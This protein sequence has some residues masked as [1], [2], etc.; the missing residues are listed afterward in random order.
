MLTFALL[1][2]LNRE[3]VR[4]LW[5]ILYYL[6]F[7]ITLVK[8]KW[9]LILAFTLTHSEVTTVK[10]YYVL[11]WVTY[12]YKKPKEKKKNSLSQTQNTKNRDFFLYLYFF[13]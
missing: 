12:I 4:K 10:I 6:N 8:T 5:A 11:C 1:N 9:M 3:E 2:S 7:G 13:F